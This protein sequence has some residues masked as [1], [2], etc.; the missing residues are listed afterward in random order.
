M[1]TVQESIDVEVPVTTAYNQWTQF[2]SFPDFMNGVESISQTSAT[3]S[4]WVTR[5]G[6]VLREFD[7]EITEQ[8]PDERVAWKS[9][10]GKS[11]AGV[12]TFH[13]L[14]PTNTRVT[15]QLDWDPETFVEK[16]GSVVGADNRQV[17]SDLRRFKEFIESRGTE[18]GAWRGDVDAPATSDAHTTSDA[19][20]TSDL[21]GERAAGGLDLPDDVI[22]FAGTGQPG[23]SASKLDGT[24]PDAARPADP[25]TDDPD[26]GG[27][28]RE[29]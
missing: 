6:G 2:E 1:T 9:V 22:G 17:Q 11:H 21:G 7:T 19:P 16:V 4:H 10:D 25:A 13:R 3:G 15:V 27:P 26:S 20:T 24:A 29:L 23:L 28:R 12:V 18:S 5:V 8:H 14:D